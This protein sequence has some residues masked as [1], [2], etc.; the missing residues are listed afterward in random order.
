MTSGY[1]NF[2][3]FKGFAVYPP[4]K[5][6]SEALE[7]ILQD[8]ITELRELDVALSERGQAIP[9]LRISRIK[10]EARLKELTQGETDE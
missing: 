6:K 9:A 5:V 2:S 3:G 4:F 7:V 10:A 8:L 1:G